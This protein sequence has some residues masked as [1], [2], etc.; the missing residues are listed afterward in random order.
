MPGKRVEL[1]LGAVSV[2]PAPNRMIPQND[3]RLAGG[4]CV[5]ELAADG[6]ADGFAPL[7]DAGIAD[8]VN[9]AVGQEGVISD[10]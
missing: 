10:L 9:G 6:H 1:R 3:L 7:A 4:N 5:R 8:A 2:D